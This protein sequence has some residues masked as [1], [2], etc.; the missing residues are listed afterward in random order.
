MEESEF[1]HSLPNSKA[2]AYFTA[3]KLSPLK[4]N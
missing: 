4:G 3:T 2:K 1:K